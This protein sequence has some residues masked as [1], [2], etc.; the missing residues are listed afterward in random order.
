MNQ[1]RS[2]GSKSVEGSMDDIV[3]ATN[4]NLAMLEKAKRSAQ[5]TADARAH[6][7]ESKRFLSP[8]LY[9]QAESRPRA[10]SAPRGA[11]ARVVAFED[12][13]AFE[14]KRDDG[15]TDRRFEAYLRKQKVMEERLRRLE[16]QRATDSQTSQALNDEKDKLIEERRA[17]HKLIQNLRSQ[18]SSLK[19]RVD[20]LVS[21]EQQREAKILSEGPADLTQQIKDLVSKRVEAEMARA[22][23]EIVA[24]VLR[25]Q[26]ASL[27]KSTQSL[28][29]SKIFARSAGVEQFTSLEREMIRLSGEFERMK[30]RNGALEGVC[31]D[32]KNTASIREIK[33]EEAH[34]KAI[35]AHRVEVETFLGSAARRTADALASVQ[36]HTREIGELRQDLENF[37]ERIGNVLAEFDMKLTHHD[38]SK[39]EV[40]SVLERLE[41]DVVQLK[42]QF[43]ETEAST[44]RFL[45]DSMKLARVAGAVEN[46]GRQLQV[47]QERMESLDMQ[48][49]ATSSS[50][51]AHAV[52]IDLLAKS[53]DAINE[54]F[55]SRTDTLRQSI[56]GNKGTADKVLHELNE[57]QKRTRGKVRD[58]TESVKSVSQI[59]QSIEAV[60]KEVDNRAKQDASWTYSFK[61]ALQR[62]EGRV[63]VMEQTLNPGYHSAPA[64]SPLPSNAGADSAPNLGPITPRREAGT[65]TLDIRVPDTLDR[66]LGSPLPTSAVLSGRPV[67][68]LGTQFDEIRAL[69]T[70]LRQ[71]I[72][73]TNQAERDEL[74]ESVTTLVEDRVNALDAK[75][76]VL[77]LFLLL[78]LISR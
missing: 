50:V 36:T 29:D 30:T 33:A 4:A 17:D 65:G 38:N 67:P 22:T 55:E 21:D 39:E 73:R 41:G 16:Q 20:L 74:R 15:N 49:Q 37:I 70:D 59:R 6:Y 71:E 34:K 78:Q 12:E 52:P 1:P 14:Q 76:V 7:I 45:E 75:Y 23:D 3:A 53:I 47:T 31:A 40:Y 19:N 28:G 24:K 64:F 26:G 44:V 35:N 54:K 32:L 60:L 18:I 61:T 48:L 8:E 27:G 42:N 63:Q 56:D 25:E 13:G 72:H 62:I 66:G 77:F 10:S 5:G 58:L 51:D 43:S 46:H 11:G 69:I 68:L 9:Q 57:S 2:P